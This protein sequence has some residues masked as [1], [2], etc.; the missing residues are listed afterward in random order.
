[1][2]VKRFKW[3]ALWKQ[4]FRLCG[5]VAKEEWF[6]RSEVV[7]LIQMNF[8]IFNLF[9]T[10]GDLFLPSG[11]DYDFLYYELIRE[12]KTI[13][14]LQVLIDNHCADS[15]LALHSENISAIVAHFKSRIDLY[16]KQNDTVALSPDE[17]LSVIKRNYG[18][19]KLTL[20]DNLDVFLPY[21]ENP[22]QV[23]FFR[24]YIRVLVADLR[25]ANQ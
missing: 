6:K 9:I 8:T 24:Q 25:A 23:S 5:F 22:A 1:M 15:V 16:T 7:E 19:L 2:C 20:L 11:N 14:A 17:V 18:S 4:L 13:N 12:S 10:Y 21:S 3:E